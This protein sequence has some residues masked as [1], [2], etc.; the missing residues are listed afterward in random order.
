MVVCI[1]NILRLVDNKIFMQMILM[2]LYIG[3]TSFYW[4]RGKCIMT[5]INLI[6]EKY[7]TLYKFQSKLGIY[8]ENAM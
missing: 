2:L 1:S 4:K 6:Q 8:F 5:G 3:Y 7:P